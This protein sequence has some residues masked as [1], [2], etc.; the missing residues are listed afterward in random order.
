MSG[1]AGPAAR[2]S[3]WLRPGEVATVSDH[4]CTS[5]ASDAQRAKVVSAWLRD[6]AELGQ[7]AMYVGEGSVEALLADLAD[8]SDP[9]RALESGALVV[10][11][12]VDLYDIGEAIDP[13]TQLAFYD[14]AVEQAITDGYRGL[15]VA[16]DITPLVLDEDLRTSHLHWEQY[17]DR[18]MTDRPL[19]P[20]CIYDARRIP[21]L[22]AISAV[23]PLQGPHEPAFAVYGSERNAA[24]MVG[25]VD[26]CFADI[27]S[28]VLAG[29]PSSDRFLDVERLGFIDARTATVL[30][31]E[32]Q[33]RALAEQ[34]IRIIG[35]SPM[36]RRVWDLCRLDPELIAS[37]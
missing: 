13:A 4:A 36:F 33:R 11:S 17:A 18:Y 1:V 7:R 19:A 31:E 24:A 2:R 23:H 3:G 28:D 22:P 20:L 37:R 16:A 9:Q 29:L 30:H 15:R 12:A 25:E 26:A 27:L 8:F 21:A 5:Y 14:G 10:A 34:P 6:G 32:L 35:A